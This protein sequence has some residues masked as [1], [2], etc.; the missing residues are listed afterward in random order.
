[1]RKTILL[2]LTLSFLISCSSNNY[3]EDFIGVWKNQKTISSTEKVTIEKADDNQL[4]L[5]IHKNR[6]R[7]TLLMEFTDENT[8]QS[9]QDI[10]GT[11]PIY[12]LIDEDGKTVL[13]D[14]IMNYKFNKLN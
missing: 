4:R 14:Y 1:M 3:N 10:F 6:S 9:V 7:Q 5:I 8:I 11:K 2:F 13:Q 12:K